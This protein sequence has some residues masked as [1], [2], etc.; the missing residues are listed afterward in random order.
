MSIRKLVRLGGGLALSIVFSSFAIAQDTTKTTTTTT[1]TKTAVVQN[2][3]G[4][5]SGTLTVPSSA[6]AGDYR[7]A[8]EC[9]VRGSQFFLYLP[10]AHLVLVGPAP[11]VSVGPAF[12]G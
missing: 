6:P 7:V 3:D 5:W 1:T 4:S 11:P 10:P 2:A 8:G 9:R 12:T